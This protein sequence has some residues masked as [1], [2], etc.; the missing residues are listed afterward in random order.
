[1]IR[2]TSF[3]V[4]VLFL[5]LASELT[6]RADVIQLTLGGSINASNMTA[7]PVGQSLTVTEPTPLKLMLLGGAIALVRNRMWAARRRARAAG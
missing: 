5:V 7:F 4:A 1:M 2:R 6:T 3:A